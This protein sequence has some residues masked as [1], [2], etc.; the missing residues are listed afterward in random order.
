MPQQDS[1]SANANKVLL[2][3]NYLAVLPEDEI[4]LLH[5]TN[6]QLFCNKNIVIL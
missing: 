6:G 1:N 3:K 2:E 4:Q 5:V